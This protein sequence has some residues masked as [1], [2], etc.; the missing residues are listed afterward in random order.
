MLTEGGALVVVDLE[1]VGH[2]DLEPLLVELQDRSQAEN[3]L[4]ISTSALC[5]KPNVHHRSWFVL[6]PSSSLT[7][8]QK[9]SIRNTN[10]NIDT[11]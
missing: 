2:V 1:A 7:A 10:P 8:K 9:L 4:L 6:L 5:A 11:Y 3:P